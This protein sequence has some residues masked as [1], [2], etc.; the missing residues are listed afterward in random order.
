MSRSSL[1]VCRRTKRRSVANETFLGLTT[2]SR[3][4]NVGDPDVN[5]PKL[6]IRNEQIQEKERKSEII[7]GDDSSIL[8][9]RS[10]LSPL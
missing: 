3:C 9:W 1:R 4:K 7:G 8:I 5:N 6:A 2:I 10:A